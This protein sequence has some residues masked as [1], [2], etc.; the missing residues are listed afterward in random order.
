MFYIGIVIAASIL[1]WKASGMLEKSA[2]T[3]SE[4]YHLPPL[5]QGTIITAVG[6]S[7]PE[8]STTVVSSLIHGEFDLGM[9]AIVGSAIFNIL[10][11]PG[12]SGLMAGKISVDSI[13]VYKDAQFYITSVA[14]LLLTF[15][16][17]VIYFPVESNQI[18]GELTRV[19]ALIP[20]ALYLLYLFLQ[21]QDTREYRK[22][23]KNDRDGRDN[24]KNLGKEWMKLLLS[25]VLI[26]AGV[27]GLLRSAIFFG[28]HFQT[29]T[30]FWGVTV[31]AAA[32]SI[33][34]A[35]VSVRV[36]K[37]GKGDVSIGNVLGSNI[38]DL[39]VAIP[40]GV[41]I[42]GSSVVNFSVAVPMMMFLTLATI[43]LFAFLRT[44]LYL[45]VWESWLLL[46]LYAIFIIWMGLENFNL[47]DWVPD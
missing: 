43:V 22:H 3:L 20:I 23:A 47:V 1:V 18:K 38:F 19:V 39:L 15:S 35:F 16:L 42:V 5:V 31:V 14:V 17:A 37:A 27:E 40:A 34:D 26:V 45:K 21:Q 24:R 6:S 32:T 13:L 28:D 36:A 29:P 4:Y 25:L 44:G 10:F 30:F 7:F 8:L 41:L 12:L 11:I 33:P 46:L 2:Q 9:A